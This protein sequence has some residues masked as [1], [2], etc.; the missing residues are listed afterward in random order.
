MYT[1]ACIQ[2]VTISIFIYSSKES[3]VCV[4]SVCTYIFVLTYTFLHGC[5]GSNS[6]PSGRKASTILTE[7]LPSPRNILLK[8]QDSTIIFSR[9]KRLSLHKWLKF[10]RLQVDGVETSTGHWAEV[11][12]KVG[13]YNDLEQGC[14]GTAVWHITWVLFSGIPYQKCLRIVSRC[15]GVWIAFQLTSVART[16][17]VIWLHFLICLL[18]GNLVIFVVWHRGKITVNY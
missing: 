5:W 10:G 14:R 4:V 13:L 16:F 2:I 7:Y 3:I 8:S 17:S 18:S 12:S 6:G 15:L 11:N 1:H 9:V